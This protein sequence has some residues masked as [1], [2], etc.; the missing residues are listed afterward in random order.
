VSRQ[1]RFGMQ[2]S[3]FFLSHKIGDPKRPHFGG[4]VPILRA[5]FRVPPGHMA[6][7]HTSVPLFESF[8][9]HYKIEARIFCECSP[10]F[11]SITC[12]DIWY[13]HIKIIYPGWFVVALLSATRGGH[14]VRR[15]SSP[16]TFVW[17]RSDTYRITKRWQSVTRHCFC[18]IVLPPARLPRSPWYDLGP[19]S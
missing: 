19:K 12:L 3:R 5:V 17:W 15:L 1:I 13:Y 10:S 16:S 18:R 9:L 8:G 7:I 4:T 11:V 6:A 2:K 14:R